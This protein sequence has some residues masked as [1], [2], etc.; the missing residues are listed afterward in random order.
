MSASYYD[1]ALS[2]FP[3]KVY[4][5]LDFGEAA[6]FEVEFGARMK[7]ASPGVVSV[8]VSRTKGHIRVG[9]R[10]LLL[11]TIHFVVEIVGGVQDAV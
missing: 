5:L 11:K 2:T 7:C 4:D 9:A 10:E 1:H 3:R 8:I 6:R